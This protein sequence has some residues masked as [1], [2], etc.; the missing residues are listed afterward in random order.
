MEN[1]LY[2]FHVEPLIK[3]FPRGENNL[4]VL[5]FFAGFCQLNK[6][7]ELHLSYNLFLGIVPPCLNNLK[8][9][10][11][12]DLSKTHFFGNISSLLFANLKSLEYIH[13]SYNQFNDLFSFSSFA[14]DSK[15]Q[16]LVLVSETNKV[17]VETEYPVRWVPLFQ[18][19][20]LM[21]PNCKLIGEFSGFLRY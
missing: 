14:S 7:Q 1:M 5:P 3:S 21:L 15:L 6:L 17:K 20:T 19:K 4:H 2:V 13:L 10:R 11:L 16:L 9:Q 8:S 12:L 18:L